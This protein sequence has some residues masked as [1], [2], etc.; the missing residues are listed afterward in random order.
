MLEVGLDI[1]DCGLLKLAPVMVLISKLTLWKPPS[2]NH[3]TVSPIL[4][5]K[6]DEHNNNYLEFTTCVVCVLAILA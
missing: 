3:F 1:N 6:V 4:I 2:F 5:F